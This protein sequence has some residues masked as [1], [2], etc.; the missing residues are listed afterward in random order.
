MSQKN[1]ELKIHKA[2]SYDEKKIRSSQHSKIKKKMADQLRRQICGLIKKQDV[3]KAET[4][5]SVEEHEYYKA[6]GKPFE[7]EAEFHWQSYQAWS[8]ETHRLGEKIQVKLKAVQK[9]QFF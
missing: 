7:S 2:L 4:R 6:R 1:I 8:D 3:A 9:Y 5:K